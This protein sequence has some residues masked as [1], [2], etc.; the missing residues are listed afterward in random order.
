MGLVSISSSPFCGLF[1]SIP[2]RAGLRVP[3]SGSHLSEERSVLPVHA[4]CCATCSAVRLYPKRPCPLPLCLILFFRWTAHINQMLALRATL[5]VY[6][7]ERYYLLSF[8]P[9]SPALHLQAEK[10][11][12]SL[13]VCDCLSSPPT[14]VL[15]T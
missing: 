4:L 1:P 10:D 7:R 12:L 3:I 14:G 5:K 9:S 13:P 2:L 8:T 15:P 6:S 11:G